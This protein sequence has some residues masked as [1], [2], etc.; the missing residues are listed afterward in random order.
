MVTRC[1]KNVLE[2][3][4]MAKL[5]TPLLTDPAILRYVYVGEP[6]R[7]K[8]LTWNTRQ[9]QGG[10]FRSTL[11]FAFWP[12]GF[13]HPIYVCTDLQ[14]L[15]PYDSDETLATALGIVVSGWQTILP[16]AAIVWSRTAEAKALES[17]LIA[18]DDANDYSHLFLEIER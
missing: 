9:K 5:V 1:V 15:N 14:T 8:L 2:K 18:C 4:A 12:A 3:T 11:G 13:G 6:S 7:A 10:G 17:D 16:E